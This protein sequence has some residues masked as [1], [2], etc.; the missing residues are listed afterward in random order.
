VLAI[1]DHQQAHPTRT[2]LNYQY[3]NLFDIDDYVR[4]AELFKTLRP[5]ILISGHGPVEKVDDAYLDQLLADGQRIAS[6]HRELLPL[7][8]I[9]LGAS[10]FPARIEPYRA[11]VDQGGELALDVAVRNPLPQPAALRVQLVVPRGWSVTPAS[12]DVELPPLGRDRLRFQVS[13]GPGPIRRA[14]LA[15][16]L[17]VGDLHLGQQAEALVDVLEGSG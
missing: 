17:K 6:L 9:D 16:D 12:V 13:P 1:G 2:V 3:R 14:R 15:A 7:D 4:A 8:V 10:G 11:S 5:N